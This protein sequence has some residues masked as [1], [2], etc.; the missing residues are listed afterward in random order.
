MGVGHGSSE[1]R[2]GSFIRELGDAAQSARAPAEAKEPQGEL[3]AELREQLASLGAE[4][5]A[6]EVVSRDAVGSRDLH[7]LGVV[8]ED[9]H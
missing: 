8:D 9:A 6:D 3:V 2:A 5:A 1:L 4:G 7:A